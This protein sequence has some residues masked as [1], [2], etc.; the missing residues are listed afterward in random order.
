VNF[1]SI[2]VRFTHLQWDRYALA[3]PPWKSFDISTGPHRCDNCVLQA[4]DADR[5]NL[6]NDLFALKK[7]QTVQIE[8]AE[9]AREQKSTTP[10]LTDSPFIA[11]PACVGISFLS[12]GI[13]IF[14]K[15]LI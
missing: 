4:Q 3:T 8:L 11:P 12:F 7:Q 6:E 5:M 14:C 2:S 9:A 13:F 1:L 15:I 10:E